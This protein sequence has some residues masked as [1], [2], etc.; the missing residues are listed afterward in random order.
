MGAVTL[1]GPVDNLT[2][3]G[4]NS[5]DVSGGEEQDA[6]AAASV[7]RR[8]ST[9]DDIPSTSTAIRQVVHWAL[10]AHGIH[11]SA[12]CPTDLGPF[13]CA[14]IYCLDPRTSAQSARFMKCARPRAAS[15]S[16]QSRRGQCRQNC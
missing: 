14:V 2:L 9:A 15:P 7:H 13:N 12:A 11:I 4:G 1:L 8:S 10:R 16:C 6:V 3:S 5:M